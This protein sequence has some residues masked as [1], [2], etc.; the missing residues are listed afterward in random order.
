MN[1]NVNKEIEFNKNDIL[2]LLDSVWFSD[3]KTLE[4]L[5]IKDIKIINVVY[6]F[7]PLLYP[8][9]Y[10]DHLTKTF[11]L[12]YKKSV[13]LIDKF[14]AISHSVESECYEYIKNNLSSTISKNK[15]D[16]FT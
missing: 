13:G 3:Y 15:F 11:E 16:F 12:W 4:D 1:K 14:I 9:F 7:I 2:I 6:D 10:D 8:Q 5:K